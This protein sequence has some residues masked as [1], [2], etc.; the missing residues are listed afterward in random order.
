[1]LDLK[2]ITGVGGVLIVILMTF[3]VVK[4]GKIWDKGKFWVKVLWLRVKVGGF[5][6]PSD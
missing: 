6:S 1:M 3:S 5:D 2:V 4:I